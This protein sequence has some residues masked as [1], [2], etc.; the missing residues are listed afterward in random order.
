MRTLCL[1]A[2]S[3]KGA[4]QSGC[5]SYLLGELQI[6]YELFVGSSVGAINAAHLAQF[7][8]GE[9]KEAAQSLKH[10]WF[11]L[12]K[13]QV[14]KDWM[15]FGKL[16][17]VWR[18][19]L[20]NSQPLQKL[21]EKTISPKKIAAAG[22]KAVV[23]AVSLNSGKHHLFHSDHPDFLKAVAA[24]ATFPG[25]FSPVK[26]GGHSYVDAALKQFSPLQIAVE[27]GAT[28]IDLIMTSPEI[29]VKRYHEKPNAME[30]LYRALDLTTDKIMSLEIDRFTLH[31]KMA[32]AGL[33]DKKNIELKVIRPDYNI[34][35]NVLEF[36]N[37]TLRDLWEIGYNDAKRKYQP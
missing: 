28:A 20:F 10:L 37:A 33:T 36:D 19:S 13:E 15:F 11:N 35:D 32:D 2:G 6:N 30:V 7:K 9:E 29:R 21:I 34:L 1:S 4:Y 18:P 24:S 23:G 5:A 27:N 14:Y 12:T 26:I 22:K 31:N 17:S 16:A 8:P 25:A 3:E